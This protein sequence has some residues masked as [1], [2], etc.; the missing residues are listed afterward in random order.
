MSVLAKNERNASSFFSFLSLPQQDQDKKNEDLGGAASAALQ[1]DFLAVRAALLWLSH[2]PQ[3]TPLFYTMGKYAVNHTLTSY[4]SKGTWQ[5]CNKCL[6]L[7]GMEIDHV[8]VTELCESALMSAYAEAMHNPYY[9]LQMA[10]KGIAVIRQGI[11]HLADMPEVATAYHKELAK[12]IKSIE[13]DLN[14]QH[15]FDKGHEI[16]TKPSA[17]EWLY[18]GLPEV[19]AKIKQRAIQDESEIER[20][21]SEVYSKWRNWGK[22]NNH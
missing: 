18:V 22:E 11:A 21:I 13:K 12:Y 19:F 7:L 1:A 14:F 4:F 9:S 20:I 6:H 3:L 5:K 17:T 2:H 15:M 16:Y 10:S 8:G